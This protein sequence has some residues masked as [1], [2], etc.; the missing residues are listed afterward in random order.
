MPPNALISTSPTEVVR[1]VQ[2][3]PPLSPEG[4][5]ALAALVA[6]RQCDVISAQILLGRNFSF[7]GTPP[8]SYR[9]LAHVPA[10]AFHGFLTADF[11]ATDDFAR[12]RSGLKIRLDGPD[13][14]LPEMFDFD[15]IYDEFLVFCGGEIMSVSAASMT[16]VGEYELTVLR[17]RMIP[18]IQS[19]AA[20]DHLFAISREHLRPLIH[21]HFKPG[22]TA[23]FK[24]LVGTNTLSEVSPVDIVIS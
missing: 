6:R 22:N 4:K 16:G 19:H 7:A 2:L 9:H 8:E 10:C 24:V 14:V 1:I 13:L 3:P 20:G 21:A 11:P 12:P 18:L 15:A 5:P 23:R 17:G